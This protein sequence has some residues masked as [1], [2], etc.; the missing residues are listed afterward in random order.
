MHLSI[1]TMIA[2][3][4]VILFLIVAEIPAAYTALDH[5]SMDS[6]E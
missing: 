4:S 2:S 6:A 1:C 3:L 5:N